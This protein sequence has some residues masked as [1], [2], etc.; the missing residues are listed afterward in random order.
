SDPNV[1]DK[2]LSFDQK[3][4]TV[5]GL[6]PENVSFFGDEVDSI[7]PVEVGRT[8]AQSKQGFIIVL[9]RLKKNVAVKQAQSEIDTLAAQ[10]ASSDPERNQG[11]GAQIQPLQEAAYG[12]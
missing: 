2:T 7:T 11:N 10:L 4:I 8:Q 6:L 3:P 9:G 5:I 1:I 12:G